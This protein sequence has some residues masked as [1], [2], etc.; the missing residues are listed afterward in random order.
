MSVAAR[1]KAIQIR[2]HRRVCPVCCSDYL[3]G[4]SAARQEPRRLDAG[5]RSRGPAVRAYTNQ[6]G[7]WRLPAT[8][9][10]VDSRYLD[11]LVAYEDKRFWQHRGVD[12]LAL[13]RAIGQLVRN[14]R[15][16]SGASTLTMQVARLLEPRRGR[17]LLAKIREIVRAVQLESNLTKQ[18]I[19]ALY[20]SLAPYGGNL[21]GIRAASLAY[22]GREPL[23]LSVGEIALLVAL[24][25][26]PELRRPDHSIEAARQARDRVLQRVR[27][28]G[29]R[30]HP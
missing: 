15:V 3:V 11:A 9:N 30:P 21:E 7:R 29:T 16:V 2:L 27:A 12:P 4:P 28:A 23:R 18:E 17:H 8:V 10:T 25:Q 26:S 22:F 6:F 20:L 13:L 1:R 24:P 19:M 14:G 5:S